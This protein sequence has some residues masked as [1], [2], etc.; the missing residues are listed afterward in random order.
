MKRL[1]IAVLLWNGGSDGGWLRAQ[2]TGGSVSGV[3][4]DPSGASIPRAKIV[5]RNAATQITRVLNANI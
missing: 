4:A 1:I 3:I 5:V 2:I